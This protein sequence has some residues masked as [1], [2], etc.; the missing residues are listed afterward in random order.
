REMAYVAPAERL[1][2]PLPLTTYGAGT[3]G[4]VYQQLVIRLPALEDEL[5][6]LLPLYAN[7]LTEL[8]VG[9]RDYL[10]TQLWQARVSGSF[11]A[12]MGFRGIPVDAAALGGYLVLSVKGLVSTQRELFCLMAETL[13]G[14]R[15]DEL[16][17]I[18][19]LVILSRVRWDSSITGSAH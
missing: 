7:V 8:G 12:A 1:D 11:N 18:R 15:F 2:S 13:D 14:V 4:L 5:V 17:R 16:D 9:D 19:V 10:E 3:N 6:D